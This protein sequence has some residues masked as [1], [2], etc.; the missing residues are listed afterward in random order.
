MTATAMPIVSD[1]AIDSCSYNHNGCHAFAV[2]IAD[3]GC[4]TFLPLS[5]S[6]GLDKVTAQVGACQRADCI[7]NDHLFCTA[8]AIRVGAGADTA[9]CLTYAAR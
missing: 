1:C 2:T 3:K 4:T 7:K 9:S 5:V 6:G 8:D